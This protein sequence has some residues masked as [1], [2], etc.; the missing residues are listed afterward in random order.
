[1]RLLLLPA[2]VVVTLIS[3]CTTS[4]SPIEFS[5]GAGRGESAIRTN[6]VLAEDFWKAGNDEQANFHRE[7][8]T[9]LRRGATC[10]TRGCK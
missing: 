7:R 2:I 10:S 3:A 8:A 9:M 6:D 4:H 5:K 1:M